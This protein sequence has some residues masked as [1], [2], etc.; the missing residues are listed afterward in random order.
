MD[1]QFLK[2][3]KDLK[4]DIDEELTGRLQAPTSFAYHAMACNSFFFF[5]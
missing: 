4:R 1:D 3:K 2:G 5:W